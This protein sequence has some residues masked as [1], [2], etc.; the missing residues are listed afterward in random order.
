MMY[1]RLKEIEVDE[2]VENKLGQTSIIIIII[3][4]III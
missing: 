1:C 2:E 3:I 4:I